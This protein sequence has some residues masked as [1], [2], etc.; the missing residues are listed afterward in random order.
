MMRR[1]GEDTLTQP[2]ALESSSERY[3]RR[4]SKS[5]PLA[6][7]LINKGPVCQ[8]VL[9]SV[10]VCVAIGEF[11]YVWCF[12]L[13]VCGLAYP[14]KQ[15]NQESSKS[16]TSR[17]KWAISIQGWCRNQATVFVEFVLF[18]VP[19]KV[20]VEPK[21]KK[22]L[23]ENRKKGKSLQRLS[24]V[25]SGEVSFT[26]GHLITETKETEGCSKREPSTWFHFDFTLLRIQ[27]IH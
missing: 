8:P 14:R 11:S 3:T 26:I 21:R 1:L 16:Q 27:M 5:Y 10:F 20:V 9:K 22:T 12:M 15:K 6:V 23:L 17:A 25:N 18:F 7:C 24:L 2:I 4:V 13:V 19:C